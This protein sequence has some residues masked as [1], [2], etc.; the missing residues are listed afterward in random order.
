MSGFVEPVAQ[1]LGLVEG[2][3]PARARV[4]V[5][6]VAE[7][8][9]DAGALVDEGQRAAWQCGRWSGSRSAYFSDCSATPL[10]VVP[11]G[12]ASTTPAAFLSTKSR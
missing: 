8:G 5:A 6:L 4:G 9:L 3:D 10:S 11:S 1:G 7:E 12:L 2:E